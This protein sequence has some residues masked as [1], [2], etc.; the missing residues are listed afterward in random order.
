M[1]PLTMIQITDLARI[2]KRSS[3]LSIAIERSIALNTGKDERIERA[4]TNVARYTIFINKK[5][6]LA[7]IIPKGDEI[8]VRV[9]IRAKKL[10][11]E[12]DFTVELYFQVRMG[13]YLL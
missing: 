12:S 1:N 9:P 7:H 2:K 8:W 11:K 13:S 4:N 6:T 3:K 5:H 10:I